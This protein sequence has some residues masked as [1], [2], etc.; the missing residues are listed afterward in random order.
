MTV[1]TVAESKVCSKCKVEKGVGEFSKNK[2]KKDGL[3]CY[4]KPCKVALAKDWQENNKEKA[5][6][7]VYRY[8][9]INVDRYKASQAKYANNQKEVLSDRYISH[10]LLKQ[11]AC[12]ISPYIINLKRQ[13]ILL[14]RAA[15]ELKKAATQQQQE[16]QQ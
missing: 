10:A 1:L 2:G 14:T 3:S 15:R 13:Q 9:A 4:C 5:R 11:K 7:K 12:Y 8:R 6:D 16:T